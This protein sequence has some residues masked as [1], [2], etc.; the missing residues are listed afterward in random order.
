M[1]HSSS[2]RFK[3]YVKKIRGEWASRVQV[4]IILSIRRQIDVQK[5]LWQVEFKGLSLSIHRHFDVVGRG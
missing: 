1:R 3:F 4:N 2:H 5:P